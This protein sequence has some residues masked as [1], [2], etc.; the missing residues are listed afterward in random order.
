MTV[1]Y[2]ILIVKKKTPIRYH[3]YTFFFFKYHQQGVLHILLH[4]NPLIGLKVDQRVT[5]SNICGKKKKS[6]LGD[7]QKK[8]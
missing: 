6:I 5:Q 1:P 3:E 7:N 8:I 2:M 4:V